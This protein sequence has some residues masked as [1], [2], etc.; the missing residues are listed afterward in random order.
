MLEDNRSP[1]SQ[2]PERPDVSICMPVYNG[3]K[4]MRRA[5]DSLL[6]QTYT[7]FVLIISD[8]AST[9]GTD[10]IC[11]EYAGRDSRIK[12]I[13]HEQ[14]L[15]AAA[16]YNFL[17]DAIETKY[18]FFAPHDDEWL[19]DWVGGAVQTLEDSPEA[20][21]ALGTIDFVSGDDHLVGRAS[22]SWGLDQAKPGDRIRHYLHTEVT[23][24]LLYGVMRH[25]VVRN[26]RLGLGETSPER[27][28]IYTIL[29]TGKI[30]DSSKMK[31]INHMSHKTQSE[32]YAF[33]QFKRWYLANLKT[34]LSTIR[35]LFRELP[36]FIAVQTTWMYFSE[37]IERKVFGRKKMPGNV[38]L[39][40][41][42]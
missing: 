33:F 38:Q 20:S 40:Q 36:F 3:A 27:A 19:K 7:N 18:F 37:M 34:H 41:H 11:G 8:N 1:S 16:N 26:F 25:S 23:D 31:M 15:G 28:L 2:K 6:E 39:F 42:G 4:C 5:L 12:Y 29:A 22:P 10:E 21:I 24:H 35:A 17:M 32:L 9:D 30:A 14:N 13:R